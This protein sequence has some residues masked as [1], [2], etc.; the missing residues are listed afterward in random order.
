MRL[1]CPFIVIILALQITISLIHFIPKFKN[2]E[3]IVIERIDLCRNCQEDREETL[4]SLSVED[5][6]KWLKN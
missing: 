5:L 2:S 3:E 1:N 4:K 6:E